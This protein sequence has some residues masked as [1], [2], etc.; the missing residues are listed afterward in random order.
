[1][2]MCKNNETNPKLLHGIDTLEPHNKEHDQVLGK[3]QATTH[4]FSSIVCHTS[5]V[6]EEL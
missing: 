1:M 5:T 6:I 4:P 3:Q 2:Q